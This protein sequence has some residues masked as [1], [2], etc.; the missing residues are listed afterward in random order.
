[1]QVVAVAAVTQTTTFQQE[2]W[3]VKE[4]VETVVLVPTLVDLMQLFMAAAA[5]ETNITQPYLVETVIKA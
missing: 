2:G 3:V 4:E 5:E 1:M